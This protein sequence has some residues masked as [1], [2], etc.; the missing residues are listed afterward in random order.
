MIALLGL[1]TLVA[2]MV[3]PPAAAHSL[4]LGATPAPDAVIA[5]SPL[6]VRLRFN[7]RIEK[8]LSRVR[9]VDERGA[10]AAAVIDARA[11][12]PAELVIA[13]VPPLAAGAWRVEW[14]VF[15]TDGHVVSGSYGFRLT[16]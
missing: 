8:S 16:P 2:L 10:V 7:N 15:S 4:L 6:E 5:T 1:A 14:Q 13:R 3:A 9:L 11:A 12:A